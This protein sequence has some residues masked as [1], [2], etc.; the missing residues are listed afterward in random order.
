MKESKTRCINGSE[1]NWKPTSFVMET[2]LLDER[3]RVK[4][5]QP[6]PEKARVYCVCMTCCLHTYIE[7]EWAGYYLNDRK[8]IEKII[9]GEVEEEDE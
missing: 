6:D 5:R 1:H 7:T 3:G 2:Q 9:K 8:S 4:I